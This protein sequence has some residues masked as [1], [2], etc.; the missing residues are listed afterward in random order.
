[1]ARSA[2]HGPKKR[3]SPTSPR[4]HKQRRVRE[5]GENAD[6]HFFLGGGLSRS[7]RRGIVR[8]PMP[9]IRPGDVVELGRHRIMCGDAGNPEHVATLFGSAKPPDLVFTSPP[10]L[11]QRSYGQAASCWDTLM[12]RVFGALPAHERTQVLVNLGLVHRNGEWL[13]YWDGWIEWMRARGW[14]R[15]GW[16]VWDK[17]NGAPGVFGG[18]PSPSHEWLFHF[19]KRAPS[20]IRKTRICKSAGNTR[21]QSNGRVGTLREGSGKPRRWYGN[22]PV[23]AFKIPSSVWRVPRENRGF[24][25]PAVF[26]ITLAA[27]IIKAY[28]DPGEV[29]YDPFAGSGTSILAAEQEGRISYAIELVPEYCQIAV[30]RWKRR[31]RNNQ[32]C[33]PCV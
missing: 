2:R 3:Q 5:R 13:P 6:T 21:G 30:D 26:P 7:R 32:A 15:F 27:E 12:Q 24:G 23:A 31:R 1:M 8:P 25:H 28:T 4:Q 18:R 16:Y 29:L 9:T 11:N 33:L 10:Y 20:S 22:K 14:K 17:E 19:N